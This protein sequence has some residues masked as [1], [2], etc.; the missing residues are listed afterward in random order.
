MISMTWELKPRHK[1]RNF[2]M[3]KAKVKQWRMDEL[4]TDAECEEKKY[5]TL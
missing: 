2:M 5:L 4:K 1:S 3:I